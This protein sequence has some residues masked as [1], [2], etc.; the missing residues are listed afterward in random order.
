[1]FDSLP[2]ACR[3]VAYLV[4]AIQL[5]STFV[6]I[7]P[8]LPRHIDPAYWVFL[9][10]TCHMPCGRLFSECSFYSLYCLAIVLASAP[11]TSGPLSMQGSTF[12]HG[13]CPE[14]DHGDAL[15]VKNR[16]HFRGGANEKMFL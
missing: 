3:R 15:H 1:M 14:Y 7:W 8:V 6:G 16:S 11:R 4:L 10:I 12:P 2:I 13:R 9:A 5:L